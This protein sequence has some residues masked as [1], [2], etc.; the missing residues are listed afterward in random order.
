MHEF[1][2]KTQDLV[3]KKQLDSSNKLWYD[4]KKEKEVDLKMDL[5]KPSMCLKDMR[6]VM[7]DITENVSYQIELPTHNSLCKISHIYPGRNNQVLN[8]LFYL[9]QM[10][11]Y[12]RPFF[13]RK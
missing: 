9:L 13:Q 12:E 2:K 6:A 1:N 3:I 5:I 11:L 4:V 7:K 10:K 8:L